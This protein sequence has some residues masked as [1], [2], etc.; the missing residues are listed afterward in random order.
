MNRTPPAI[1]S[2]MWRVPASGCWTKNTRNRRKIAIAAT[3]RISA[4]VQN[5]LSGWYWEYT[6]KIESAFRRTYAVVEGNRRDSRVFGLVRIG[7]WST[8]T[9]RRPAWMIVSSV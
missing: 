1:S 9:W 3:P 2:W 8:A 7:T 5:T 6:R 4:P